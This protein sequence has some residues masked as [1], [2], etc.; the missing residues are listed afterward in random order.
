MLQVLKDAQDAESLLST[1][2]RDFDTGQRARQETF[3]TTVDIPVYG[4]RTPDITV[5][6]VIRSDQHSLSLI[7]ETWTEGAP[8]ADKFTIQ[9]VIRFQSHDGAVCAEQ[10][11]NINNFGLPGFL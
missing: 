5:Y 9:S 4:Q 2:W 7:S 3:K 6:Y 1:P 8:F 11:L 10:W